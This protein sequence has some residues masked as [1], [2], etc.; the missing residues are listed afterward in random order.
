[1]LENLTEVVIN[2][3]PIIA[4]SVSISDF[5]F[6]K[7]LVKTVIV[8]LE[9]QKEIL[10]GP[11][12]APGKHFLEIGNPIKLIK[13]PLVLRRD[14]LAVLDL[15]EA[16][17]I[18]TAQNLKIEK[19]CIDEAAGRRI[20]RLNGLSVTGSLGFLIQAIHKGYSIDLAEVMKSMRMF[21]IWIS[22]ALEKKAMELL[23]ERPGQR[24]T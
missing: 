1:M 5:S 10:D 4:L 17:V 6:F 24:K 2:T 8:P 19:V 12:E 21:G 11:V 20:A 7:S 13:K 3:G 22:P 23:E 9:V 18:Q 14:L 16:S 15:G